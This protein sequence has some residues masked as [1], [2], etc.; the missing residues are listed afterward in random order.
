MGVAQSEGY[1]ADV[2]DYIASDYMEATEQLV[3]RW[4]IIAG[5]VTVILLGIVVGFGA[6]ASFLPLIGIIGNLSQ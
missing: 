5:P 2:L 6:T 1:L 3:R 4:V